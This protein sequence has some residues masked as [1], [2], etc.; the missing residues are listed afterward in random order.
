MRP[1]SLSVLGALCL[2]LGLAGCSKGLDPTTMLG[3]AP[4][5]PAT[6]TPGFTT[7]GVKL[8][9]VRK[10][11]SVSAVISVW[12]EDLG[13]TVNYKTLRCYSGFATYDCALPGPCPPEANNWPLFW[14][15]SNNGAD[16]DGNSSATVGYSADTHI[17]K[18]WDWKDRNGILLPDGSYVI[19]IEVSA[20]EYSAGNPAAAGEAHVV[21]I[22]NGSS[23][24]ASGS[25]D[26]GSQ[27]VSVNAVWNP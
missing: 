26:Q 1:G 9:F 6:P 25:I 27:L 20:H 8:D 24:N 12:V 14:P 11:D 10:G 16:T 2:F 15:L 4:S 7:S 23:G 13:A 18:I 19:R 17:T 21:I 3:P 5:G 22:K